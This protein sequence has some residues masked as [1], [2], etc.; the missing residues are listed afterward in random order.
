M[1]VKSFFKSLKWGQVLFGGLV[2]VVA[3]C[4]PFIGDFFVGEN[5]IVT[6][7]R[8]KIQ[9]KLGWSK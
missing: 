9:E 5:G 4:L 7:M 1:S 3:C 2:F 6:T 8:T